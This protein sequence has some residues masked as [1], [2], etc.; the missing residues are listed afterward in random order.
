MNHLIYKKIY[1]WEVLDEKRSEMS[2]IF[3]EKIIFLFTFCAHLNII[4]I[5]F[6]EGKKKFRHHFSNRKSRR[7]NTENFLLNVHLK[8]PLSR[9]KK[10]SEKCAIF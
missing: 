2:K 7:K 9:K 10:L 1:K 4:K 8:F 3:L 5:H 6:T